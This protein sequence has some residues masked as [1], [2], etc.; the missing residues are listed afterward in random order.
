M[1]EIFD[2]IDADAPTLARLHRRLEHAAQDADLLDV[3]YRTLD[4]AIGRLLLASTPLG[5]VRVAFL[6]GDEDVLAT[7]AQR[8]SPRILH[9]P[10]R[11]D[12]AATE[13]EEYLAGRRTEFDLPL[14]L[15]LAEGFRRQ[16]IVHLR[17]IGYGRRESYATVAAAVGS[18]KA[19][20][21]VGSACARN[22]LPLVI[23]CH[24]VVRTDGS[25]GQYA[26][27]MA[28]K[29]TLLELEAA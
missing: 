2:G 21:A 16:V 8:I 3:A 23:P 13:I 6:S 4:T 20:R 29:A 26:G 12:V 28:A 14:D 18:P 15:R 10:A 5:L 24:R 22:P 11:L 9:A 27:G 1:T 17:E 19:V 7:L 25:F